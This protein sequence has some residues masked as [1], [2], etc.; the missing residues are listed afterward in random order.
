M[1]LHTWQI[2]QC[3]SVKYRNSCQ[4]PL[5]RRRVWCSVVRL[6]ESWSLL[7]G[8]YLQAD[9]PPNQ[10]G[11]SRSFMQPH[12]F[13]WFRSHFFLQWAPMICLD[14][15]RLIK[16][17]AGKREWGCYTFWTFHCCFWPLRKVSLHST[18]HRVMLMRAEYKS[19]LRPS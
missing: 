11:Y 18:R 5:W 19:S 7:I 12:L 9:S 4:L 14:K 6:R 3:R 1:T 10:C 16:A 8:K 13:Y 15:N 2:L 17:K